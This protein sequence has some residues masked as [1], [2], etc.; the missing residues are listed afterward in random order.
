MVEQKRDVSPVLESTGKFS[1]KPRVEEQ[2]RLV[3]WSSRR[4][5]KIEFQA[6]RVEC[7]G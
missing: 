1:R 3:K 7:V 5:Q 6:E 2:C 4:E